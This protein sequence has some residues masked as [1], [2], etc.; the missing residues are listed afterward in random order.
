MILAGI[1]KAAA[2]VDKLNGGCQRQTSG[3]D[4]VAIVADGEPVGSVIDHVSAHRPC[5]SETFACTPDRRPVAAAPCPASCGTA[6]HVPASPS[7]TGGLLALSQATGSRSWIQ[8]AT[9]GGDLSSVVPTGFRSAD[10]TDGLGAGR[11]LA[12]ASV[13]SCDVIVQVKRGFGVTG[14]GRWALTRT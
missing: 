4:C 5:S 11:C 2:F 13:S 3:D 10:H 9:T 6:R 14:V 8:S 1:A 12:R 7:S